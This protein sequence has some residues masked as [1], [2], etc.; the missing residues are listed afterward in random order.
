MWGSSKGDK[1]NDVGLIDVRRRTK[2]QSQKSYVL[3]PPVL[4]LI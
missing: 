4:G 1:L 2:K 3:C